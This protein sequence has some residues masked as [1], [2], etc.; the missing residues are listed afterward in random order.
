MGELKQRTEVLAPHY[1]K[2]IKFSG[3][4][5][6]RVLKFIPGLIK[7]IFKITSTNF[8]EDVIKWDNLTETNK[9]Y[10]AWR[11]KDGKDERTTLW[12]DVKVQG[13]Q[14][15]KT[16]IGNVTIW[17]R[18]YL[19]TKFPYSNSLHKLILRTYSYYF[20]SE[21]RR[22]YAEEARK[23]LNILE[24]EIKTQLNIGG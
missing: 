24:K 22:K 14:N 19:I 20:Y 12:V 8:F 3:N 5:P 23:L 16:K 10:A 6:S 2:V 17:L 1:V 18:S 21:Q 4:H 7:E 11:G 13:E 9:F 15:E